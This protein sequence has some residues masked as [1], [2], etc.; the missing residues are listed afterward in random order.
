MEDR[1]SVM[2]AEKLIEMGLQFQLNSPS[3]LFYP[4]LPIGNIWGIAD[5]TEN[6]AV[7]WPVL[8][9]SLKDVRKQDLIV[10]QW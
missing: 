2:I 6:M 1:L 8:S 3:I 4:P 10:Q 7:I 9:C 5:G